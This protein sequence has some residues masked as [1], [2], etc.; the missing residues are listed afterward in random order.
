VTEAA[1]EQPV[2]GGVSRCWRPDS[3]GANLILGA[4]INGVIERN[5]GDRVSGQKP[6]AEADGNHPARL[7]LRESRLVDKQ[8]EFFRD[9]L[10][11]ARLGLV[12]VS[13]EP[14]RV[15]HGNGVCGARVGEHPAQSEP[16]ARGEVSLA[17]LP[18]S[19]GSPRPHVARPR[20]NRSRTRSS[21]L[22][23]DRGQQTPDLRPHWC[24]SGIPARASIN[25]RTV[26]L[27][28]MA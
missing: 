20:R 12:P 16:H 9:H 11:A 17:V 25:E 1:V 4:I 5:E 24:G 27:E 8:N 14:A 3:F 21:M 15:L 22:R 6:G 18:V 13:D 10:A 26:R 2:I 28:R 23:L 7:E 19:N